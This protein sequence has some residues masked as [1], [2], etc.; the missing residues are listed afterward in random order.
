MKLLVI[1]TYFLGLILAC[2]ADEPKIK[3][4]YYVRPPFFEE[5]LDGSGGGIVASLAQKIFLK[6][7]IPFEW[8]QS[9]AGRHFDILK[10]PNSQNCAVGW[11]KNAEREAIA[12]FS[13][14][15]YQDKHVV[16]LAYA[17][18]AGAVKKIMASELLANKNETPILKDFFVYGPFFDGLI[19]KFWPKAVHLNESIEEMVKLVLNKK[20]DYTLLPKE[21][22]EYWKAK[23]GMKT[24]ALN[25]IEFSDSPKAEYRYILCGKNVPLSVIERLNKVIAKE[26]STPK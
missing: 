21:E 17:K 24:N 20:Y 3:L 12:N 4:H 2:E 6:A 7:K 14:P 8:V 19:L 25:I 5:Q 15:I 22:A 9:P 16:A 10:N 18:G 11:F 26:A 1:C 13:K 23:T